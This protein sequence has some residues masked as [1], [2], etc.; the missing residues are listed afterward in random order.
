VYHGD[1]IGETQMDLWTSS[2]QAFKEA[3]QRYNPEQFFDVEYKDFVGNPHGTVKSIYDGFDI[4]LTAE[5]TAAIDEMD[6]ESK[7][8]K[9]KA[10]HTY[11]LADYGLTEDEVRSAFA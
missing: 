7:H 3:R 10:T 4:E 1:V 6:R 2:A 11:S 9:T 5:H 8:G